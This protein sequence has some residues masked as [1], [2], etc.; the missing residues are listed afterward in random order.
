M[1]RARAKAIVQP[2]AAEEWKKVA[3]RLHWTMRTPEESVGCARARQ[4]VSKAASRGCGHRLLHSVLDFAGPGTGPLSAASL[5][6]R[7]RNPEKMSWSE[8][9]LGLIS[10]LTF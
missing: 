2:S 4:E 3:R 10:L 6:T 8:L 7:L 9:I 5:E 1:V